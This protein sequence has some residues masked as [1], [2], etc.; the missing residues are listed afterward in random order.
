MKIIWNCVI[1]CLSVFASGCIP[2]SS[3]SNGEIDRWWVLSENPVDSAQP[4]T[5]E[6]EKKLI[7]TRWTIHQESDEQVATESI[8]RAIEQLKAGVETIEFS[9]SPADA[10]RL[11]AALCGI[12]EGA[13]NDH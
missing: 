7:P 9:F 4:T 10:S 5:I 8:E 2:S 12:G 13:G 1:I 6:I 11:S 3:L